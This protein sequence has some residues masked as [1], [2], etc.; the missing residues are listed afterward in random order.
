MIQQIYFFLQPI[1]Y[2]LQPI[3]L[4]L[5]KSLKNEF[6]TEWKIGKENGN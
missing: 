3:L 5:Q 1:A 2:S 4:S 6:S